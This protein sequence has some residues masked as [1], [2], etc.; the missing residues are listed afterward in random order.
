M[1]KASKRTKPDTPKGDGGPAGT[2][3][4]ME[5]LVKLIQQDVQ[6][7]WRLLPPEM[8]RDVYRT[9]VPGGV[10]AAVSPLNISLPG[11][12]SDSAMTRAYA[13]SYLR[14]TLKRMN[15]ADPAEEMLVTQMVLAHAR[16]LKLSRMANQETF[17]GIRAIAEACDSASN[18]YRRLLLALTE[19]RHPRRNAATINSV[20]QTNIADKQVIQQQAPQAPPSPA[21]PAAAKPDSQTEET[22][23]EKGWPAPP[24]S[25]LPDARGSEFVADFGHRV[26]PWLLTRGPATPGGKARS[27]R[28]ALRHG[29]RTAEAIRERAEAAAL[30]RAC[31]EILR[32]EDDLV[33]DA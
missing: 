12:K 2:D 29:L 24:A 19:Y 7:Y 27:S 33:Q 18:T 3:A 16:L 32:A 13:N 10:L 21:D 14:D 26:K 11:G 5:A 22:S 31:R 28:N 25:L 23:N 9:D 4:E 15:A 17:K 30:L 8:A 20:R 1:S 6:R